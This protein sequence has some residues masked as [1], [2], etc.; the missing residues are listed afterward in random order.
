MSYFLPSSRLFFLVLSWLLFQFVET[1]S[2]RIISALDNALFLLGTVKRGI[3]ILDLILQASIP[4]T[5]IVSITVLS[6]ISI[7]FITR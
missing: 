6:N 5:M 7:V 3:Y 4:A 1:Y 2:D